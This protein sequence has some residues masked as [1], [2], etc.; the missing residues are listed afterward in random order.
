MVGPN[1]AGKTSILKIISDILGYD[2]GK[3]S[4]YTNNN[5]VDNYSLWAKRNI[6]FIPTS[7]RG[8]RLKN[9]VIDNVIYFSVNQGFM[10][11]Y[12]SDV[13]TSNTLVLIGYLLW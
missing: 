2:S 10:S 13:T 11:Y 7:E 1:G 5:Q 6:S 3:I 4:V 9:S 12:S 8:L